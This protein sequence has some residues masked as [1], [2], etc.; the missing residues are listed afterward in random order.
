LTGNSTQPVNERR[1]PS[2]VKS[3]LAM[4]EEPMPEKREN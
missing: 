4:I 1:T 3:N 2:N